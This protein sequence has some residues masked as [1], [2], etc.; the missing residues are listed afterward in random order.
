MVGLGSAVGGIG[1]VWLSDALTR[2]AGAPFPW[3][4]LLVNIVGSFLIG[5][6]GALIAAESRLHPRHHPV[7]IQFL[8]VGICGGFTTFSAFSWQTLRL[9]QQ[10]AAGHALA[11][12]AASVLGCLAAVWV[13]H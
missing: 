6:L 13:G 7:I 8:M 5:L 4:T 1:R 10:G 3:G 12:I 2:R 9:L 11:N